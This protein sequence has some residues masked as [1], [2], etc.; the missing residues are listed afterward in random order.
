M[1]PGPELA[2]TLLASHRTRSAGVVTAERWTLHLQRDR[3]IGVEGVP[4]LL[5]D[6]RRPSSG[7]FVADL[8]HFTRAGVPFR[9]VTDAACSGV[10][11]ALVQLI[12]GPGTAEWLPGEPPPPTALELPVGLLRLFTQ[13]LAE[14]RNP[15]TVAADFRPVMQALLIVDPEAGREYALD[16]IARRVLMQAVACGTLDELIT[17]SGRSQLNRTRHAWRAFD[18]LYHLGLLRLNLMEPLR[19]S[20]WDTAPIRLDR[21]A[22]TDRLEEVDEDEIDTEELPELEMEWVSQEPLVE[23]EAR[24]ESPGF[25]RGRRE[26]VEVPLNVYTLRR[27]ALE[28]TWA[29]PLDVVGVSPWE[30]AAPCNI[31]NAYTRRQSEFAAERFE[32]D[33]DALEAAAT[34]RRLVQAAYELLADESS[35]RR[36][37]VDRQS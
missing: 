25:W 4:D 2:S 34:C 15:E 14:A 31:E 30:P 35:R 9:R 10:R 20:E 6:L 16:T 19:S 17:L 11:R 23:P 26:V 3:V 36:W 7:D 1:G 32:E 24:S 12:R 29:N 21:E 13:A 22:V 37:D 28:F 18:L 5:A 8:E 33:P 27:M